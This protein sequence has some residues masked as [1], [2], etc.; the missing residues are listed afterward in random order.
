MGVFY[1]TRSNDPRPDHIKNAEKMR[2]LDKE[3]GNEGAEMIQKAQE[4]K[5]KY[6]KQ[7]ALEAYGKDETRSV[8][9]DNKTYHSVKKL[10]ADLKLQKEAPKKKTRADDV[11][12]DKKMAGK[13]GLSEIVD[14]KK[15]EEGTGIKLSELKKEK[16]E[17]KVQDWK[18]M[19]K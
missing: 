1:D 11:W 10:E 4:L 5:E 3:L 7:D 2:K 14:Q 6:Q 15:F 18:K 19:V 8:I 16:K 17:Q 12:V 13:I 9:I